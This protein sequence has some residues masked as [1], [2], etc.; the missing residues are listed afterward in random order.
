M[1]YR[2]L[3]MPHARETNRGTNG[4]RARAR[5]QRALP[6]DVVSLSGSA[7]LKPSIYDPETCDEFS[8]PMSLLALPDELVLAVRSSVFLSAVGAHDARWP[9]RCSS[10]QASGQTKQLM[11]H[12]APDPVA[13]PACGH[14]HGPA[15]RDPAAGTLPRLTHAAVRGVG[16]AVRRG[17]YGGPGRRKR[18]AEPRAV[19]GQ[20]AAARGEGERLAGAS[21]GLARDGGR[22][23]LVSLFCICPLLAQE[24]SLTVK[25]AKRTLVR[26]A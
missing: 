11:L 17:P 13:P 5:Q 21:R 12:L 26:P 16:M 6:L 1:R 15:S 20:A 7:C 24:R 9:S 4:R 8:R 3:W 22:R 23:G 25:G 18:G 19:G 2:D 10:L 14:R